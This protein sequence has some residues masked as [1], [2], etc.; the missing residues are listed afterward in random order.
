MT[1]GFAQDSKLCCALY[2]HSTPGVVPGAVVQIGFPAALFWEYLL[3]NHPNIT[4]QV[5]IYRVI[6]L[7]HVLDI[8]QCRA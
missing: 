5:R 2:R 1:S 4:E 6:M 8:L 3:P 7:R